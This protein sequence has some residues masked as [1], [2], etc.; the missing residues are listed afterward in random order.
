MHRVGAAFRAIDDDADGAI[1]FGEFA[2]GR[3]LFGVV[4]GLPPLRR[5]FDLVDADRDGRISEQ[6]LLEA[7]RQSHL[8][9]AVDEDP[10]FGDAA[11][12]LPTLRQR[13]YNHR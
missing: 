5:L 13:A 6:E 10:L 2:T 1:D 11:V 12:D 7:V 4:G 8:Q 3:A 9:P